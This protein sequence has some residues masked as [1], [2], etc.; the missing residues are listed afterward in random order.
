MAGSSQVNGSQL[1]QSTPQRTP[2]KLILYS[3]YSTHSPH[4]Y[5]QKYLL[6]MATTQAGRNALHRHPQHTSSELPPTTSSQ[7]RDTRTAV[8]RCRGAGRLVQGPS[9]PGG[10]A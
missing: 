7:R 6:L 2:D 1:E 5:F 9:A 8:E 3:L 10:P 4:Q